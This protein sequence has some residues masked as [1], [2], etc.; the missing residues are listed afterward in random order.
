MK[1]LSKR[2]MLLFTTFQCINSYVS[3]YLNCWHLN[4]F[5]ECI[6][7]QLDVLITR[8]THI[9]GTTQTSCFTVCKID[10]LA[11]WLQCSYNCNQ[12]LEAVLHFR[13]RGRLEIA[14]ERYLPP[15]GWS[16]VFYVVS[17]YCVQNHYRWYPEKKP[18]CVSFGWLWLWSVL[19]TSNS[20]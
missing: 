15:D 6:K 8:D 20:C 11:E 17:I 19:F 18:A 16:L 5:S 4:L 2:Y 14:K 10:Y 13:F 3:Y 9:W 7:S 12:T 1:E